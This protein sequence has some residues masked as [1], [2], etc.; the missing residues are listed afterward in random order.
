MTRGRKVSTE[1]KAARGD[2]PDSGSIPGCSTSDEFS[3]LQEDVS[4]LREEVQK[5]RREL[6]ALQYSQYANGLQSTKNWPFSNVSPLT[7][8]A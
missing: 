3:V 1:S 7:W 2:S 5:L 6:E 4:D 8:T